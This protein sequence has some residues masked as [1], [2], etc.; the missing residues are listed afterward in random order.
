MEDPG[1]GLI[2]DHSSPRPPHLR[3]RKCNLGPDLHCPRCPVA[4]GG[5]QACAYFLFRGSEQPAP[6]LLNPSVAQCG[7]C[8]GGGSHGLGQAGAAAPH[9]PHP[10]LLPGHGGPPSPLSRLPRREVAQSWKCWISRKVLTWH[11]QLVHVRS[12]GWVP[13]SALLNTANRTQHLHPPANGA[14]RGAEGLAGASRQSRWQGSR[15]K[16]KAIAQSQ[17]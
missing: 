6:A 11:R 13:A 5:P 4:H 12:L 10:R 9:Y 8:L 2:T 16:V 1:G 3:R 15:I 7:G 14:S 17:P